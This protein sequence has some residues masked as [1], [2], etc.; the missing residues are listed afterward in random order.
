MKLSVKLGLFLTTI[1]LLSNLPSHS[2]LAAPK[3]PRPPELAQGA[4]QLDSVARLLV[5]PPGMAKVPAED[6]DSESRGEP[7][8]FAIPITVTL[9]P[10]TDGTWERLGGDR[11]LWRLR[12]TSPGAISLNLGFARYHM[13][14][15]GKLWLYTPDYQILRD[16]FTDAV[17]ASHGQL[18]TPLLEGDQIVV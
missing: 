16:P 13:P 8:R 15:G 7:P 11:L 14:S 18:W 3:P 6:S 10:T 1:T 12:I 9:T 5:Q 4:Q 17:N 2:L